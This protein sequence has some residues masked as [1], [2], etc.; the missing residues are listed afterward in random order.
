MRDD[1]KAAYYRRYDE[2]KKQGKLFFPDVIFKDVVMVLIVF[3]VALVLATFVGVPLD[4][5][6]D[7]T[8]STYVPRP[9]WYFL[10]LFEMLK[11]F[12]GNL[13]FM[14][15]LVIPGIFIVLLFVL[16]F[17]DRNPRRRY[18]SRPIAL[19]AAGVVILAVGVLSALGAL[20]QPPAVTTAAGP[21]E[22]GKKLTP[23]E[24]DG[25][26]VYQESRCFICHQIN[27]TGGAIG[28]DLSTVGRR[29]DAGWLVRHLETPRAIAPGTTMPEFTLSNSDLMAMTAY[30]LTLRAREAP[31]GP[32]EGPLSASAESGKNTYGSF[33][34]ACHPGGAAGIGPKVYGADF[35]KR[36]GTD[37]ALVEITR[38]GKGSMPGFSSGQIS[39]SQ[40]QDLIAYI[41]ALKEPGK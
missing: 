35:N 30:L 2:L 22:F 4:Q 41:R 32:V 10:F 20:S 15:I 39:D 9:E 3:L 36:F 12:P 27:G 25:R 40:M 11:Y 21:L 5:E 1:L 13:E 28:P 29:L 19:G 23:F 31:I 18:R 37:S 8:S 16:P 34:N 24:R 6:A 33:C 38:T 14:G 17:A 26:R 7:P